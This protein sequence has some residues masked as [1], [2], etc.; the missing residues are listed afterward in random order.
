MCTMWTAETSKAVALV[1]KTPWKG[2]TLLTAPDC[3]HGLTLYHSEVQGCRP[4]KQTR[5]PEFNSTSGPPYAAA[6]QLHYGSTSAADHNYS[7][8][9]QDILQS[10][11]HTYVVPSSQCTATC[12][13]SAAVIITVLFNLTLHTT[14]HV[15]LSSRISSEGGSDVLQCVWAPHRGAQHYCRSL[16]QK[17]QYV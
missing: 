5:L 12:T 2:Y 13:R 7:Y 11:A 16:S 17:V 14:R 4:A 6:G 8:N 3:Q 9:I 1:A 15:N 10:L